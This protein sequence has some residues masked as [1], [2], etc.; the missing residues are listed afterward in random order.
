[1]A[2]F[3]IQRAIRSVKAPK[4]I[5]RHLGSAAAATAATQTPRDAASSSSSFTF[6]DDADNK[7][8]IKSPGPQA[9]TSSADSSVTMP[10]SFM[11]GSIVGKRFY[12]QVTTR[13]ADDGVGWS[14]MLDYRTLKTPSK[15]PLKLPT[16]GLAKAV[17]AEWEYQVGPYFFCHFGAIS[18]LKFYQIIGTFK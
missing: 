1:M 12:K 18:S 2:T 3:L 13:E 10:P 15:R 5:F 11:T 4:T 17:A 8:Y 16:L 7:I 9:A 14:V 6:D